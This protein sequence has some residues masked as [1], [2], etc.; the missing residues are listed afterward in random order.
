MFQMRKRRSYVKKLFRQE[1]NSNRR[2]YPRRKRQ[3]IFSISNQ[4]KSSLAK[5]FTHINVVGTNQYQSFEV[6]ITLNGE[7]RNL[8]ALIDSGATHSF[9]HKRIVD[10]FTIKPEKL[11]R[12]IYL[13]NVN[14]TPNSHGTVTHQI[15]TKLEI[16]N[17]WKGKIPLLIT[18]INDSE[19]ILGA[20]WLIKVNP[21]IN[22]QERTV[23]Y[24]II[25]LIK[26]APLVPTPYHE[27][28]DVFSEE[29]ASRIPKRKK[30]DIP[31]E[32]T[33]PPEEYHKKI[34]KGGIYHMD[35]EERQEL[36]DW[37]TDQEAKGY[38]KPSQSE[39]AA[40][41]FFVPK[42]GGKKRLV[43]NYKRLNAHTKKDC[44]PIPIMRTL[45]ERLE[46]A[47][48]FTALDLRWGYHNVRIR[49][50]D[51]WK[52]AFATPMGLYE[53]TV[54][55]FGLSNSPAT[56]QRMMDDIL[57]GTE[58]FT[59]VYLDDILIYS[60]NLEE[61][62]K[63]VIEVLK[64]LRD[65]DLF[66]R[67]EKCVFETDTLEYLGT[68][69]EKGTLR[70]DKDKVQSIVDW[71]TPTRVKDIRSFLGFANFY[72]HFIKGFVNY[73]RILTN[74]TKKG[75][76]WEWTEQE[77]KAFEF[78]KESFTKAPVLI[79][80]DEEKQFFLETDASD[81]G[82]GVVLSQEGEDNKMHP[83]AFYSNRLNEHKENYEIFDKE[84][85][86]IMKALKKWRHHLQGA[87][88]PV[89][90]YSDHQSLTYYKKPQDLS[91]RQARWFTKLLN[92]NIE[93]HHQPGIK[94]ARTDALSR[95]PD[96]RTPERPKNKITLIK[97]EWDKNPEIRRIETDPLMEEI[98]S[99][100]DYDPEVVI[101]LEK[102]KGD[103][104][105]KIK[106]ALQDWQIREGLILYQGKIYVPKNDEIKRKILK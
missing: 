77:Q 63:H 85:L 105:S 28:L 12:P 7:R 43:Q 18:E 49:E 71:P 16:D 20:N 62:R 95:N 54:M 9:I 103:V 37:V 70:M 65:N 21:I 91:P 97:E 84:M 45:T 10:K 106:E 17:G 99:E 35:R 41:V 24:P 6:P 82:V 15:Y 3:A 38:I 23:S 14:R 88:Y 11:K 33:I 44:Y 56:F 64:R 60:K 69:I 67:P 79:M 34:G 8:Q 81:Y 75:K 39:I 61:H 57:R 55:L 13:L 51:E 104:P 80:P 58:H 59:V 27:F 78:L 74:L 25:R 92:F 94:S 42:K 26:E 22:W 2:N 100:K 46:G 31:I 66:A 87:K 72:R 29:K 47:K 48:I 32:L 98:I 53:P 89:K 19:I 102:L 68:W 52:A 50:G 4:H 73:S 36:K 83:V 93:L 76:K 5:D 1:S 40:S 30:W 101:A 86:A 96:W 90:V